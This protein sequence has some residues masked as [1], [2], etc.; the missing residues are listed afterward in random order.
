MGKN[1]PLALAFS[2]LQLLDG[3]WM[4]LRLAKPFLFN[5][6]SLSPRPSLEK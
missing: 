4:G 2:L 6:A 5:N 3:R 1:V